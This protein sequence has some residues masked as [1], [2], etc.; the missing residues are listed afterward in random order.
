M[1]KS[2]VR[3]TWIQKLWKEPDM[4][5]GLVTFVLSKFP[6]IKTDVSLIH[7]DFVNIT[8][9]KR[10]QPSNLCDKI[11]QCIPQ[12]YAAASN[13]NIEIPTFHGSPSI[14]N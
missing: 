13:A 12:I 7:I 1:H 11:R 2:T 9:N 8:F 4:E 5:R 14:D 6:Q 3:R 10:R